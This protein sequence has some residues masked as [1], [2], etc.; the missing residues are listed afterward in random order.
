MSPGRGHSRNQ[1]PLGSSEVKGPELFS[2]GRGSH[3]HN[4]L[5]S[6][7]VAGVSHSE[8]HISRQQAQDTGQGSHEPH[9]SLSASTMLWGGSGWEPGTRRG[10]LLLCLT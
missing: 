6:V 4:H 7:T 3:D 9:A 2:G 5:H 1:E 8:Q 10:T